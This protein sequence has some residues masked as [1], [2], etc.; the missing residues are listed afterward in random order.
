MAVIGKIRNA[1]GLL[2]IVIGG[3]MVAFI[4]GDLMSSGNTL[5]AGNPTEI[6]EVAGESIDGQ[7]FEILVQ[8]AIENYKRNYNIPSVDAT[9]TDQIREQTWKQMTEDIV[10]NQELEALGIT[11]T[12]D[13]LYDMVQGNNPHPQVTS[14][15]TN[16][17]T[18][19]FDRNQVMTFLKSMEEDGALKA[20]WLSFEKEL[21][22]SRRI[23]KFNNLFKKGITVPEFQAKD[24][25]VS[26]NEKYNFTLVAKRYFS[27]PDSTI[28]VSDS[29]LRSYYNE[30][31][32][33]YEQDA[34]RDVE[35]VSFRVSP[36][37][38][39]VEKV[40]T[41][42]GN[43]YSEF[44]GA[45]NDTVFVNRNSDTRFNPR[46]VSR[47]N[48]G[49]PELID[50]L[51][52]T[53]EAGY[54]HGPYQDNQ[55]FRMIKVLASKES[56]DSV[57][58][59]HILIGLDNGPEASK[60]L[61]D[62]I[63]Q[64]VLDGGDFAQLA[65]DF[66]ADPGSGIKGGELGWFPEGAMVP[67]FND[68]CFDGAE[69]DLVVVESQFGNHIIEV[70]TQ[71][72]K[73]EKRAFALVDRKVEASNKTRQGY[74]A[75]ADEF[76]RGFTGVDGFETAVA[77][78]NLNKR[79]ASNL[80]EN[81]KEIPGLESP[82]E[83]VRWAY[84]SKEGDVSKAYELGEDF[85]VAILTAVREDGFTEMEDLEDEITAAVRKQKLGKQFSD[86]FEGALSGVSDI[87][88]LA[89]NMNLPVENKDGVVFNNGVIQGFGKE[90]ALVGN[91]AGLE[92]G[93]ISK[94][95]IGEQGVF[96]VSVTTK[97]E[98]TEPE[99]YLADQTTIQNTLVGR[100]DFDLIN[101]L[102]EKGDISDK[103]GKFY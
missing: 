56:P 47:G 85:V 54:V 89:D 6:G 1:S 3:A 7:K 32:N 102:K 5:F 41:W 29:D 83:I 19:Q 98:A 50:S 22:R 101:A 18:G 91:L 37:T 77:E 88:S 52:F 67:S 23:E 11:V 10:Y 55:T 65:R 57:E 21:V 84:Q 46:W 68:A 81:S 86:E 93:T 44:V 49:F 39:D 59:R 2:M 78:Q 60:T 14:A 80:K 99:N 63:H 20:R 76:S 75:T 73:S 97:T 34:S 4:L 58:A 95:I 92:P 9:T 70:M 12:P 35:F 45:A 103:R 96:V 31:K 62:S 30:H 33:E 36:S 53:N 26:K 72:E 48:S 79:L 13:E 17:E 64:L 94:P 71:S 74:Y 40:Q 28:E 90:N 61:A 25:Y 42:I 8:D 87:Q 38:D 24:G 51:L 82:R 66:S 43:L 15:F 100:V 69:G 16:P 27:V